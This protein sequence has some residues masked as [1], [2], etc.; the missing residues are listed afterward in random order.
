MPLEKFQKTEFWNVFVQ[1]N[2][3]G[4]N[5]YSLASVGITEISL[6]EEKTAINYQMSGI[7]FLMKRVN[8][9]TN[10]NDR[11]LKIKNK[12]PSLC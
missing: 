7:A 5:E 9:Y 12:T 6:N 2:N 3:N 1:A 10:K 4:V 11:E 8:I